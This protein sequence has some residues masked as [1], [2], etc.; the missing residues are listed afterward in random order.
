MDLVISTTRGKVV[1]TSSY[2]F[3][4][5][6]QEQP[7]KQMSSSCTLIFKAAKVLRHGLT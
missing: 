2:T 4:R 6:L 7:I 3:D 5:I 1:A